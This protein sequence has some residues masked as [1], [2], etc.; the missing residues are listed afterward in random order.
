MIPGL[1]TIHLAPEWAEYFQTVL[2]IFVAYCLFKTAEY[3]L[4]AVIAWATKKTE[5]KDEE[6]ES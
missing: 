5:E 6:D 2:I 4:P 1:P 3:G